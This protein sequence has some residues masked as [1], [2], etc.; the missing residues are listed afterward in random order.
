MLTD[1]SASLMILKD[2]R[3]SRGIT[4]NMREHGNIITITGTVGQ[5]L[6]S[7]QQVGQLIISLIIGLRSHRHVLYHP[8]AEYKT[9]DEQKSCTEALCYKSGKRQRKKAAA[10][11]QPRPEHAKEY[12]A[13]AQSQK[14]QY[15]Y[16]LKK[17]RVFLPVSQMPCGCRRK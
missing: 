17:V 8:D 9:D 12:D 6:S 11:I 10:Y 14:D 13:H 1:A 4:E 5:K 16:T 2:Y 3:E 15:G 7:A